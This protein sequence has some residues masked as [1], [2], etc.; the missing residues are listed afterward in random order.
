MVFRFRSVLL[1]ACATILAGSPVRASTDG[2][3]NDWS[4]NELGGSAADLRLLQSGAS[5]VLLAS[6]PASLL[7]VSWRR[8]HG[9]AVSDEAMAALA[10]P[11][12]GTIGYGRTDAVTAWLNARKV[13]PSAL[14]L[15]S[16]D[17]ERPGPDQTSEPNCLD[18]AF[19]TAARTLADR[20]GAH[21]AASPEASTWLDGQDAVFRACAKPV[22]ALPPLPDAAP[23]WLAADRRYQEA[24]LAFYGTLVHGSPL[25]WLR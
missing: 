13:V 9:Q 21:G 4:L 8:L 19:R 25:R 5:G 22:A 10:V 18:D 2:N 7:F 15:T 3:V 16:I 20:A 11:C 6:S 24:A 17:T 14:A 23:A 1:L 12:C